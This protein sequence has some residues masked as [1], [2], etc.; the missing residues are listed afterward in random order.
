M[1]ELKK[2]ESKQNERRDQLEEL[3]NEIREDDRLRHE[4]DETKRIESKRT[5]SEEHKAKMEK[6]MV[7]KNIEL[8]RSLSCNLIGSCTRRNF[9]I[10]DRGSESYS[11]RNLLI[12]SSE[13]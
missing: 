9:S 12:I 2:L 8:S 1:N 4:R 5:A 11:F 6:N 13:F 7:R 10:S 3:F